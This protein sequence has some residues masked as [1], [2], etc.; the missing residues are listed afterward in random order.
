MERRLVCA[1]AL[2]AAAPA[3][4][5]ERTDY[6]PSPDAKSLLM[7]D[8]RAT[9]EASAAASLLRQPELRRFEMRDSGA[10][11]L[12]TVPARVDLSRFETLDALAIADLPAA[13]ADSSPFALTS[14]DGWQRDLGARA[15]TDGG[16]HAVNDAIGR[17]RIYR[18]PR[19]LDATLVLRLDG[20]EE[21]PAF[22][23]G[24]GVAAAL[25]QVIPRN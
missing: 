8:K 5:S 1:M 24:G 20:R 15:T 10:P 7:A 22:S 21:S 13:P 23:V 9:F 19:A 17:S 12:A 4:A 6:R 14:I 25:W 2:L 11:D 3:G 16:R 18:P